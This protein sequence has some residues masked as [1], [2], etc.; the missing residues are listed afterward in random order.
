MERS[1]IITVPI[2]VPKKKTLEEKLQKISRGNRVS[3]VPEEREKKKKE[4]VP[5]MRE[6]IDSPVLRLK[7]LRAAEQIYAIGV[8]ER[9][10]KAVKEDSISTLKYLL[11][12]TGVKV[13]K[14]MADKFSVSYYGVPR[15]KILKERLL[16]NN[17]SPKVIAACTE[18]KVSK[19]LKVSVPGENG[20]EGE[21]NED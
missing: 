17:V 12:T 11:D 6:V 7:I 15:S 20:D 3:M 16:A 14:F 8:E 18:T 21:E 5:D 19:N 4:P 13:K 9:K 1:V 10:L 2:I